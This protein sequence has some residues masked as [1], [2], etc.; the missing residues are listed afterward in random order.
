MIPIALALVVSAPLQLA[1]AAGVELGGGVDSTV[2]NQLTQCRFGAGA[3]GQPFVAP[4]FNTGGILRTAIDVQV[5]HQTDTLRQTLR[6]RGEF[7]YA[8]GEGRPIDAG[9]ILSLNRYTLVWEPSD[10]WRFNADASY[11][12]GRGV[13]LMQNTLTLSTAFLDTWFGEYGLHGAATRSVT[14]NARIVVNAGLDGRQ[15]LSVPEGTPRADQVQVTEGINGSFELGERDTLGLTVS[16]QALQIT[17]LGDWLQ[18]VTSFVTWRHAWNDNANTTLSGGVD[19]L[20]DQTDF[21]RSRWNLGPYAGVTYQQMV[22][23]ANL[24]V[25]LRAGYQFTTVNAVR[26]GG[27]LDAQ[28]RCPPTQVIAGGAGR[29]AS[30]ALLFLWRPFDQDLVFQG[31]FGGDYGVSENFNPVPPGSTVTPTTHDVSNANLSAVA[32]A[33]WIITRGISAFVRYT[34]L[35]QHVEEPVGNPDVVRHIGLAGVTFSVFAGDAE[36]LLG[37]TP[38]EESGTALAIR[39]AGGSSGNSD[40]SGGSGGNDGPSVTDDGFGASET[41]STTARPTPTAIELE[42]AAATASGRPRQPRQPVQE[43][44]PNE[45]PLQPGQTPPATPVAPVAPTPPRAPTPPT[46]AAP[47]TAP[48]TGAA[49]ATPTTNPATPPTTAPASTVAPATTPGAVTPPIAAPPTR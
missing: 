15:S 27:V 1:A 24:G 13:L 11:N 36:E 47:T 12:V 18:R 32:G 5:G 33:R 10:R 20:Q 21:T 22:P 7:Y 46:N 30:A 6:T 37:V 35:Y 8:G 42:E 38:L 45:R 44:A 49:P 48:P 19:A 41:T 26:C 9:N 23:E 40:T 16:H 43:A 3:N 2:A 25:V 17:G 39:G 34:F 14:D 29:V 4:C 28:G 31:I